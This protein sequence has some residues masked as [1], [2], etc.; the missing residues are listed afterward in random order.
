MKPEQTTGPDGEEITVS[1]GE[2]HWSWVLK[3]ERPI[4]LAVT[5]RGGGGWKTFYCNTFNI[6]PFIYLNEIRHF[7]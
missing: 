5:M 2:W 6:L 1:L 7:E 4:S 3:Q